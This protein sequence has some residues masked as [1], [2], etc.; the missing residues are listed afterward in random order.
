MELEPA[1]MRNLMLFLLR[2]LP[3]NNSADYGGPW[4]GISSLTGT[5]ISTFRQVPLQH[6]ACELDPQELILVRRA[7][8]ST[9]TPQEPLGRLQQE[10]APSEMLT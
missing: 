7:K 9:G 1:L 8:V 2:L 10:T 5:I 6:E 4:A 3:E